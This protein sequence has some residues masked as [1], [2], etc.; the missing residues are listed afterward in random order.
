MDYVA[1]KNFKDGKK[2]DWKH[3]KA[4]DIYDGD[5]AQEFLKHGL[6][7]DAKDFNEEKAK[8]IEA[9]IKPL[10]EEAKALQAKAESIRAG[11]V[12]KLASQDEPSKKVSS[13]K[14]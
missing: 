2:Q 7:K 3:Y 8:A 5:N 13:G 12:A 14:K 6:I 1:V 10:S 4:G 9:K 11:R